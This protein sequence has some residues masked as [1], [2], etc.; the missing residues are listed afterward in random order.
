MAAMFHCWL[1]RGSLGVALGA[2][3]FTG[4]SGSHT[5]ISACHSLQMTSHMPLARTRKEMH[6]LAELSLTCLHTMDLPC[7]WS[8]LCFG[9]PYCEMS[10]RQKCLTPAECLCCG[11][12]AC[13]LRRQD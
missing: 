1:Y 5:V 13:R 8:L 9:K 2:S 10:K 7:F 4:K 3:V 11:L 12:G 6:H